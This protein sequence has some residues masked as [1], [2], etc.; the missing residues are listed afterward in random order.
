[1]HI[2]LQQIWHAVTLAETGSYTLAAQRVHLSQPA[3][4][5]SI[6]RLE[7]EFNAVLFDRTPEG[8]V[9]TAVG[10]IVIERGAAL[11]RA[12]RELQREV[13][14]TLGLETGQLRIG[15]GTYSANLSVGKACGRL[16]A[17]HPGLELTVKVG[18]WPQLVEGV[19]EGKLDIAVVET[20]AA[21]ED[22][23]LVTEQLPQHY[24]HF[25]CR[26]GHPLS[27][28]D[29]LTLAKIKTFPL[30][31]TSLPARFNKLP[32]TIR[33][34]T[35][36]LLRDIVMNSDAIGLAATLQIERDEHAGLLCTLPL[37]LPYLHTSYGF[38]SLSSR[39]LSPAT[40]AFMAKMREVEATLE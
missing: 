15:A 5:R 2:R 14:L 12:T 36:N 11:I 19:L 30:V 33:V 26:A 38:V 37:D 24:G 20:S 3:L 25:F 32:T 17:E 13:E 34:D 23:R 18:D 16:L 6:K 8:V 21:S 31:T 9:P 35:F 27:T 4:S 40:L 28:S 10:S 7:A 22:E 1:M 39:T 29:S